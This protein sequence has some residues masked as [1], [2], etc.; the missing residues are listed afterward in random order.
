MTTH[1][2]SSI[3]NSVLT[4]GQKMQLYC[5]ICFERIHISRDAW[6]QVYKTYQI[7]IP[8]YFTKRV[9]MTGTGALVYE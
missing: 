9:E 8:V 2:R 5:I 1:A 3:F 4:V 6:T 7:C